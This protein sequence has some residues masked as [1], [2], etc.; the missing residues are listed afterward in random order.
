VLVAFAI[1]TL[2][3][4]VLLRVYASGLRATT[5]AD[6]YSRA[7]A[8][9]QSELERLG[10]E[11]PLVPGLSGGEWGD[12]YRWRS[13]IEA[14]EPE[15]PPLDEVAPLAP[16]RVSVTVLWGSDERARSLTLSSVRL[17]A[18]GP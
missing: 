17:G 8:L 15:Q 16:Y 4:G 7:V 5:L 14:F 10:R 1:L 9:A 11:A 2:T 6:G 12:G 18:R 13:R 3:L